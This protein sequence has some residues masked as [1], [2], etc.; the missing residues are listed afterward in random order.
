[1]NIEQAKEVASKALQHLSESLAQGEREVL[2]TYLAA[3]GKFHR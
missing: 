3:M 2:R 1:M